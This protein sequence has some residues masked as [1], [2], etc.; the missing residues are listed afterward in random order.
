MQF[1]FSSM[2]RPTYRKGFGNVKYLPVI[3]HLIEN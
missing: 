1:Q 3:T 2:V